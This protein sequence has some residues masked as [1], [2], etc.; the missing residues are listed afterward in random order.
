MTQ[1]LKCY[2]MNRVSMSQEPFESQDYDCGEVIKLAEGSPMWNCLMTKPWLNCS[3]ETR[4]YFITCLKAD[5]YFSGTIISRSRKQVELTYVPHGETG[6]P[7][8]L[9]IIAISLDGMG[10]L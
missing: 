2:S 4:E 8:P 1:L 5:H 7:G 9:R 10:R 6:G 3:E